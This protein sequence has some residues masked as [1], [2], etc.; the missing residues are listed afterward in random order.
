MDPITFSREVTHTIISLFYFLTGLYLKIDAILTPIMIGVKLIMSESGQRNQ[1]QPHWAV[2][3]I[4]E[5]RTKCS[6]SFDTVSNM[7]NSF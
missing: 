3:G 5:A 6:M 2:L 7:R 1:K 4:L